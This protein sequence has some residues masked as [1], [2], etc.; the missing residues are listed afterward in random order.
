MNSCYGTSIQKPK[1]IKH[2][3]STNINGTISNQGDFV[4]SS[5]SGNEGF[6]NIIQPYVE[7]YSHPHFAKVILD[8]F[9]QKV[10][11]IKSIVHVLFQN[12]DAFIVNETDYNN[13]VE[14]G[15]VHP[16]E[17]GKLKVE[18]IF[19]SVKFYSKMKWIGINEDNSEF[20]HCI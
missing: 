8:G 18:H 14:L 3:Y 6:V 7:H 10:Q 13:L 12:I 17:L 2:K 1:I 16:T 9:Q 11:E 15:Y 4:I 5:E 20:R 19:K